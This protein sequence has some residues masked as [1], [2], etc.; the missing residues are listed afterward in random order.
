MDGARLA[1]SNISHKQLQHRIECP[2]EELNR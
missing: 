2:V 1:S